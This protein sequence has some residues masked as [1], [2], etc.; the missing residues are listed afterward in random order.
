MS[1]RL[2]SILFVAACGSESRPPVVDVVTQFQP[3]QG[4]LPEGLAVRDGR[5]YVGFAPGA[6]VVVVDAAGAVSPFA[7]VPSTSGGSK[8]Y[9]LGLAFDDAGR[10]YIGQAS[11]DPSVAPGI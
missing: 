4:Q 10:L 5:S 11:F 7:T 3:Q 8:G 9:T 1:S 6:A 2:L